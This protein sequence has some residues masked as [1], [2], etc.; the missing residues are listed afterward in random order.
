MNPIHTIFSLSP[1]A[2]SQTAKNRL[3]RPNVIRDIL[4]AAYPT[5]AMSHLCLHVGL[6]QYGD[7][8]DALLDRYR[9]A[10]YL[11]AIDGPKHHPI[12][13]IISILMHYE[14]FVRMGYQVRPEVFARDI[15]NLRFTSLQA[16]YRAHLGIDSNGER[17]LLNA[18]MRKE[19]PNVGVQW[20]IFKE[21]FKTFRDRASAAHP[22]AKT[23][24]D[25]G[26]SVW[27]ASFVD[28]EALLLCE[29][30]TFA[31]QIIDAQLA[32]P[33]QAAIDLFR[34][35]FIQLYGASI[36]PYL[37]RRS[38]NDR[39]SLS[40]PHYPFRNGNDEVVVGT[41]FYTLEEWERIQATT[42]QLA[43]DAAMTSITPPHP[44]A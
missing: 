6:S 43:L 38:E 12:T 14:P 5:H 39:L 30:L 13:A 36:A 40:V 25:L 11:L 18:V 19:L 15:C 31:F 7:V 33:A 32:T 10:E 9:G 1:E 42:Q 26:L 23:T 16:E 4:Q 24:E 35:D 22:T 28:P 2:V 17:P 8:L 44:A 21:D 34:D 41:T 37:A 3:N 29:R 27:S 20:D